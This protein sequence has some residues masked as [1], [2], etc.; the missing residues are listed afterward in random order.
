[1]ALSHHTMYVEQAWNNYK[2][3]Q[4]FPVFRNHLPEPGTQNHMMAH[5]LVHKRQ[6]LGDVHFVRIRAPVELVH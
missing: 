3:R 6:K 4:Y 5:T 2:L 1:M